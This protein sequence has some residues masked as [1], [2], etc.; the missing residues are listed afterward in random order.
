MSKG[1]LRTNAFAFAID[2]FTTGSLK[3]R[4]SSTMSASS[5]PRASASFHP[6][7]WDRKQPASLP[8]GSGSFRCTVTRSHIPSAFIWA[9]KSG[10][11]LV[12]LALLLVA[13][14]SMHLTL[15]K[16]VP[17]GNVRLPLLSAAPAANACRYGIGG[18]GGSERSCSPSGSGFD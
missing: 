10:S 8:S 9:S 17:S 12:L 18:A 4:S 6:F 1:L 3:Y 11:E 14:Y 13:R 7:T 2:W 15:G 16:S 5:H